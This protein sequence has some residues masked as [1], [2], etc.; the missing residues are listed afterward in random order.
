MNPKTKEDYLE[1]VND[2]YDDIRDEY[3]E[4]LKE[5]KYLT[6][7]EAKKKVTSN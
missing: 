7:T 3:Y 6:Y 1:D 2:E 4:N 5:R